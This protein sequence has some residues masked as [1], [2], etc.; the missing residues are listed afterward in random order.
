MP[1]YSTWSG[2]WPGQTANSVWKSNMEDERVIT[3]D[4]MPG[5]DKYTP[6]ASGDTSITRIVETRHL[7]GDAVTMGV[8]DMK[9]HYV[10]VSTQGLP[11]GLYIVRQKVQGRTTSKMFVKK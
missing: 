3:I 7:R 11:Q 2:T 1:W 8:Y 4:N 9:G 6:A 5:W 10:G